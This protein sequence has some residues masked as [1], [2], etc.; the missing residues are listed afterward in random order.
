[1]LASMNF[2]FLWCFSA[3]NIVFIY[4]NFIYLIGPMSSISFHYSWS[5][6][7]I[8]IIIFLYINYDS[9]LYINSFLS[10]QMIIKLAVKICHQ[11]LKTFLM[12]CHCYQA[13]ILV[14]NYFFWFQLKIPWYFCL[15]NKQKNPRSCIHL[16]KIL[17]L[18]EGT[19]SG[20][21]CV[22][23]HDCWQD[24]SPAVVRRL[25]LTYFI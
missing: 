12:F 1:M 6:C 25:H 5:V 19:V 4:A 10:S 18:S 22:N 14:E 23:V 17:S 7:C 2:I 24:I 21:Q 3:I 8:E 20:K 16:N 9:F 15:K 13:K 11:F